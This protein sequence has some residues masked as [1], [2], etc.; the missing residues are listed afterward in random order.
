MKYVRKA[1]KYARKSLKKRYTA[2]PGGRKYTGGMRVGKLAKDVMYLKSVLNPEKK[3]F[4]AWEPNL[5][6]GQVNGND[7][8][9]FIRDCTPIIPQ[10]V[11]ADTRNGASVK[12]HSSM[13]HFQ[14]A[15]QSNAIC[16]IRGVLE[17]WE[18]KGDPYTGTSFSDEKWV[19]NPFTTVRDMNCQPDP[20]NFMK[21]RCIARRYFSTQTDSLGNEKLITDVKIPIKYNKGQGKHI[22]YE[23]NTNNVANGQMY[24]VIRLDRGNFGP[25]ST[26]N[27]PDVNTNTGL[28]FQYNRVDYYYDN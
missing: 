17:I 22:R 23:K 13:W 19:P 4:V 20:D 14:F 25:V 27:V 12:L 28:L 2:K 9:R 24:L 7:D 8:G 26:L 11:T 5:L 1:L 6:V 15:Q 18:V 3:R 16:R 21:S 10:G